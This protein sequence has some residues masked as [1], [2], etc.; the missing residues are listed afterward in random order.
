M[1]TT[2]TASSGPLRSAAGTLASP[3]RTPLRPAGPAAK[4]PLTCAGA[5]GSS[6]RARRR[7]MVLTTA[8][9]PRAAI[10]GR[11]PK[12]WP[13]AVPSGTPATRASELPTNTSAVARPA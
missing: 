1:V 3:A 7:A 11:Q 12:A 6:G 2:Q 4:G 10:A 9:T 8:T 13:S 5:A